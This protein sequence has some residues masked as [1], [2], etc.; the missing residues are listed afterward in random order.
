ML[1]IGGPY[2]LNLPHNA[3]RRTGMVGGGRWPVAPPMDEN[4]ARSLILGSF[5]RSPGKCIVSVGGGG[6][7]KMVQ[8]VIF[9]EKVKRHDGH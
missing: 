7:F 6:S 5:V 2:Y 4:R 8:I 3:G 1:C 9:T